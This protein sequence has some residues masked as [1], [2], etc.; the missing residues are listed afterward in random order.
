MRQLEKKHKKQP[1]CVGNGAGKMV[2]EAACSIAWKGN[3][4]CEVGEVELLRRENPVL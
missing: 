3:R 2:G 4:W 1:I